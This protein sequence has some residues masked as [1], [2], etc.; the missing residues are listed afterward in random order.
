MTTI[1]L[2]S[3]LLLIECCLRQAL[4]AQ[5]LINPGIKLGYTFGPQGGFTYGFEVSYT[6]TAAVDGVIRGAVVDLEQCKDLTMLHLGVEWT[7]IGHGGNAIPWPGV[8]IGPSFLWGNEEKGELALSIIPYFGVIAYPYFEYTI[9]PTGSDL[10]QIGTYLK[11]PIAPAGP[12]W[13]WSFD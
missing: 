3:V 2:I 7:D 8:C 4:P 5:G 6:S 13:N 1:R 10:F 12:I 11:V 9:R